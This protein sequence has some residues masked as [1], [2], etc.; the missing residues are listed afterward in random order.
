ML[1]ASFQTPAAVILLA[2][3]LLSCFAGYR[4]FRGVL[5]FF[6]FV[7]GALLTSSLMGTDQT[8]WMIG[9]AIV[10]GIAGALILVA[11]YFVGVA[12][13][14]AG[15][16]A[17]AVNLIWASLGREPH[18]VIVIMFAIAGALAALALQRYVIIG[19]TAFGG[20]WTT[21]V[22]GLALMGDKMAVEAAARNNVWLAYPMNPA[23]G[24][25]WVIVA[26]LAL[27][28]VGVIVQLAITAKG[29]KKK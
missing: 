23:P 28:I 3:G 24:E 6:G 13:I 27:G 4:V 21:I 11:A 25:K 14:G 9:G 12:L 8:L 1:P 2:G 15:V 16:G 17:L 5:G 22:G 7:I 10:G 19:A 26:W 20:A 29:S 18:I